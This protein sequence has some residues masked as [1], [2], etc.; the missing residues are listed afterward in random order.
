M[1]VLKIK[2]DF[3]FYFGKNKVIFVTIFVIFFIGLIFGGYASVSLS[4]D[5]LRE[6]KILSDK[7]LSTL[8]LSSVNRNTILKNT[9]LQNFKI[10]TF[11]CVS[12]IFPVFIPISLIQIFFKGFRNGFLCSYFAGVYS[13]KGIIFSFINYFFDNFIIL[14]V[15]FFF[16][17]YNIKKSLKNKSNMRKR[18]FVPENLFLYGFFLLLITIVSLVDSYITPLIARAVLSINI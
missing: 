5:E 6:M 9:F 8:T 17:V 12:G 16:V 15:I 2:N 18:I 10:I 11:V 3:L 1:N 7:F 13:I 14:P 4:S